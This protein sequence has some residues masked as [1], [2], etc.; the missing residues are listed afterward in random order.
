[1]SDHPAQPADRP[2]AQPDPPSL[3]TVPCSTAARERQDPLLGTAPPQHRFL[4]VEQDGGWAFA[5]FPAL[6]IQEDI[7]D[8][9]AA[10]AEAAGARV[11][12]IRRPGRHTSSV[13]LTR[14]WC[15]VDTRAPEGAR[16]TWG[17]WAYPTELLA[18]VDRL[19]ELAGTERDRS[20]D[21]HRSAPAAAPGEGDDFSSL[22]APEE[23]LIL[24]C[25][26]GKKDPCC[27]VRGRPVAAALAR[28]YPE[29]T[30]ECSHTGGDRFAANVVVLPDGASYG[31]LDVDSA[32]TTIADHSAGRPAVAHLR[33]VCGWA[34]PVQAAI[35]AVHDQLGP[36]AP[37]SVTPVATRNELPTGEDVAASVVTL[38]LADGRRVEVPVTEH[39][40]AAARLTCRTE[41]DKVSQVPVPGT[42]RIVE[43]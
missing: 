3:P 18:A 36:L 43:P 28:R 7:R 21:P 34:R 16:V 17:T 19:E 11:M 33:G 20:A 10:R 2:V 8:E 22:E 23:L 29:A 30:W 12:L 41:A 37:G 9:V 25:T 14:S 40:R 5:G 24:V 1:M 13:C 39:V 35:V 15:V 26:H 32:L 4:L 38:L 6:A 31:G 27:A 42:V